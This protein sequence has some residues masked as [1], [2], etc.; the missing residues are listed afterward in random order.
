MTK[1]DAN[2]V[3]TAAKLQ[4]LLEDFGPVRND[5]SASHIMREAIT[6]LESQ[7]ETIRQKDVEIAK[8]KATQMSEV[9]Q[10]VEAI[11]DREDCLC[12][13]I[14]TYK[15]CCKVECI[16]MEAKSARSGGWDDWMAFLN[17]KQRYPEPP[18]TIEEIVSHD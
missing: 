14:G 6:A 15:K 12:Q 11:A 16:V 13:D 17:K 1:E 10:E 3:I 5:E 2:V 9:Q 18:K 4:M 7:A 8:L